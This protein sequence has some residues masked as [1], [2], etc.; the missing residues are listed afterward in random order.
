M[1]R[2]SMVAIINAG[3]RIMPIC[4]T[5]GGNH[6]YDVGHFTLPRATAANILAGFRRNDS[7]HFGI[8][9]RC[10]TGRFDYR[11][12][13]G[14]D[15]ALDVSIVIPLGSHLVPIGKFIRRLCGETVLV[16]DETNYRSW[17]CLLARRLIAEKAGRLSRCA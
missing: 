15:C 1:E 2:V 16:R 11:F 5:M 10:A 7:S 9:T 6:Q 12:S 14:N 3:A 17:L 8:Q 13:Q 4:M